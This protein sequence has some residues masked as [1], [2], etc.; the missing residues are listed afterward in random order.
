MPECISKRRGLG[1]CLNIYIIHR[2]NDHY[3][4]QTI[5]SS[6]MRKRKKAM[7]LIG[8]TLFL[9]WTMLFIIRFKNTV[10]ASVL[11]PSQWEFHDDLLPLSL[12]SHKLERVAATA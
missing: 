9:Y 2:V 12:P 3:I 7:E 10:V 4:Y 5:A 1:L 8:G 11:Q 6:I